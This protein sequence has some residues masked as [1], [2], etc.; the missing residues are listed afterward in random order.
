MVSSG[1]LR[2]VP[3]VRTDVSEELSAS[4]IRVTRIDE[5][6]TTLAVTR[7]RRTLR[8]NTKLPVTASVVPS[9]P[10]LVTLM[11]EALGSSETS[12]LTRGTRRNIPEDTILHSHRRENLKS[13]KC[14]T[15][16]ELRYIQGKL[17]GGYGSVLE[18]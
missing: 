4:F 1:M 16:S 18:W 10:I 5:L 2:S 3:L 14:A 9:S 6:R 13:Y 12:V 17:T 11:K 7:N 15:G 8:R